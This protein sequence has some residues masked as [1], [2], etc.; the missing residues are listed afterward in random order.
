MNAKPAIAI[1]ALVIGLLA[2]PF[3]YTAAGNGLFRKPPKPALVFPAKGGK[4]IEPAEFMRSNHMT[5]LAHVRDDIVRNGAHKPNYHIEHCSSCH[6]KRAEF[7]DRC[8]NYVGVKPE[9]W[10]CHYLP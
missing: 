8:H 7:C 10:D 2:T 9:C 3:L 5:L 4:C 6:T 1:V